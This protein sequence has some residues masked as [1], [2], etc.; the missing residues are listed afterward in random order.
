MG[1]IYVTPVL[2]RQNST[3]LYQLSPVY[4]KTAPFFTNSALFKLKQH[5]S[6]PTQPCF[7]K[8]CI[9]PEVGLLIVFIVQ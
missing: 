5:C 1:I 8:K 4:A 2:L 9:L 3:V 7:A 6:F